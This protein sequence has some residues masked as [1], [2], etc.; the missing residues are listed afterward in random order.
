[1]ST[2]SNRL[3][4]DGY[5]HI[6]WKQADNDIAIAHQRLKSSVEIVTRTD[7]FV[8]DSPTAVDSSRSDGGC[9]VAPMSSY[10]AVFLD[11]FDQ[12]LR[13]FG[14]VGGD[15]EVHVLVLRQQSNHGLRDMA[16]A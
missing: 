9:G 4:C 6:R 10:A 5:V 1:M 8:V 2:L 11:E 7:E 3:L 16:G 15:R 14:T 12:A 13:L